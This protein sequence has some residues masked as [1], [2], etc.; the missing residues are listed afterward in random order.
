[1]SMEEGGQVVVGVIPKCWIEDGMVYWP[2]GG[3]E[4][5]VVNAIPLDHAWPSYPLVKVR[6]EDGELFIKVPIVFII[7][8]LPIQVSIVASVYY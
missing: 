8:V 6:F 2:K 4:K 3:S 7:L 1:M 5:M